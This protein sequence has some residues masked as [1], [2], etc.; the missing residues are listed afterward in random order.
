MQESS[1][2]CGW[3]TAQLKAVRRSRSNPVFPGRVKAFSKNTKEEAV[4]IFGP[5]R[6]LLLLYTSVTLFQGVVLDR[7][8]HRLP[9]VSLSPS[10]VKCVGFFF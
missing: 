8:W 7:T 4:I 6:T 10:L 1:G 5:L 3:S 9:D 2:L